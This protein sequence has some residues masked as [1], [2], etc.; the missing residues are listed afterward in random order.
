MQNYKN[1]VNKLANHPTNFFHGERFFQK[2]LFEE[3]RRNFLVVVYAL[4]HVGEHVGDGQHREFVQVLVGVERNGVR[5]DHLL[6]RAV[7]DAFVCRTRK[8][9]VGDGGADALGPARHEH[10]GG[11]ADRARRVDAQ[12]RHLQ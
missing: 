5:H 12:H 3:Y 8:H 6:Q 4:D 9:G 1:G 11:H 10:V 2:F 7:I